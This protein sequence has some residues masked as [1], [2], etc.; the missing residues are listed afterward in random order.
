MYSYKVRCAKIGMSK[1]LN[2]SGQS[3]Q[4]EVGN[5]LLALYWFGV[6]AKE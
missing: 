3:M 4:E 1:I 6:P 2:N 5:H